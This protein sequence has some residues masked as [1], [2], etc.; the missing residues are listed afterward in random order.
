MGIV[1]L[2][3]ACMIKDLQHDY[4]CIIIYGLFSFNVHV[5]LYM[6]IVHL[7]CACMII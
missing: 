1:H 6:G 5:L 2:E 3:C 4:E 7:G